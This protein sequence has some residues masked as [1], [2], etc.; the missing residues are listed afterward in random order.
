MTDFG[1]S[2]WTGVDFYFDRIKSQKGS[3]SLV[4][5]ELLTL[6]RLVDQ[7]QFTH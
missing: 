1:R 3:T 2:V 5:L 6:I 7:K 4:T